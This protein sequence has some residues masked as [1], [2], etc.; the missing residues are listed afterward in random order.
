MLKQVCF[1]FAM[2][3]MQT[4]LPWHWEGVNAVLTELVFNNST[5]FLKLCKVNQKQASKCSLQW[6]CTF[7]CD[8]T[9]VVFLYCVSKEGCGWVRG[10]KTLLWAAYFHK[11]VWFGIFYVFD[12]IFGCACVCTVCVCEICLGKGGAD[13]SVFAAD[14][15]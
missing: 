8:L 10:K 14:T 11:C 9:T 15:H 5:N 6:K 7:E 2:K 1:L 4:V 3:D 12:F 13:D